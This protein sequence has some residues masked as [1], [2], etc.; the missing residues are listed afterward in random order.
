MRLLIPQPRCPPSAD[1]V[2]STEKIQYASTWQSLKNVCLHNAGVRELLF[3][4]LSLGR[5]VVWYFHIMVCV[6]KRFHHFFD[7]TFVHVVFQDHRHLLEIDDC[8]TAAAV[9]QWADIV[10]RVEAE[11]EVLPFQC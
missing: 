1:R 5:V 9:P 3:V 11:T 10:Y 6:I 8:V 2:A 4:H 7:L